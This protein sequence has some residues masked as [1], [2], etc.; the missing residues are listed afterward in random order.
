MTGAAAQVAAEPAMY[1][2]LGRGTLVEGS[3]IAQSVPEGLAGGI[4]YAFLL[5]EVPFA[6]GN[7]RLSRLI[8]NAEL[9]RAG[10]AR[11]IASMPQPKQP[12]MTAP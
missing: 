6:D 5:S 2:L 4:S 1:L 10:E 3:I 12:M 7:G 8:M 9:S 11:I